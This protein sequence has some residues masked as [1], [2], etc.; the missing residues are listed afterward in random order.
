MCGWRTIRTVDMQ[1]TF[2]RG[3]NLIINFIMN[4]PSI[5]LSLDYTIM[6]GNPTIYITNSSNLMVP[7]ELQRQVLWFYW[8]AFYLAPGAPGCSSAMMANQDLDQ[9]LSQAGLAPALSAELISAGWTRATFGMSSPQLTDLEN[10]WADFFPDRERTF[11]E[12][13]QM[14]VA[15][16]ACRDEHNASKVPQRPLHRRSRPTAGRRRLL[17]SFQQQWCPP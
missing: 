12:K 2:Q 17:P 7:R 5:L 14:R 13:A 3:E 16:Q 15:W 11:L 10:H 8:L 4:H 6:Y 1:S 9:I